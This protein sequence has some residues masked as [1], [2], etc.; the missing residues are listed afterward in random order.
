MMNKAK[1][2]SKIPDIQRLFENTLKELTALLD[3][4]IEGMGLSEYTAKLCNDHVKC[5]MV[6]PVSLVLM[7]ISATPGDGVK[8]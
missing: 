1:H 6:F 8:F 7:S 5:V 4:A 2:N 3:E